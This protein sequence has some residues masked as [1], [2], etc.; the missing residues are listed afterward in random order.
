MSQ[1][2]IDNQKVQ[3]ILAKSVMSDYLKGTSIKQYKPATYPVKLSYDYKTTISLIQSSL[4]FIIHVT[5]DLKLNK[6]FKE[7]NFSEDPKAFIEL[8]KN[9]NT[10][11]NNEG[12]TRYYVFTKKL[13][14]HFEDT[15]PDTQNEITVPI[16]GEEYMIA[17]SVML[18]NLISMQSLAQNTEIATKS[19]YYAKTLSDYAAIIDAFLND[20][21]I[22]LQN[23]DMLIISY[24]LYHSITKQW[25]NQADANNHYEFIQPEEAL[26]GFSQE[27]INK[28]ISSLQNPVIS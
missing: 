17:K 22:E 23:N 21:D 18:T 12:F 27:D 7:E 9:A 19:N 20:K 11:I 5:K 13:N 8:A 1:S 16:T 2:T 24:S 4:D 25:Q 6:D 26:S 28:F 10:Q 3:Q 15:M 14:R